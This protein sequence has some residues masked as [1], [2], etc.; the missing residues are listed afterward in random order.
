MERW[1]YTKTNFNIPFY[2]ICKDLPKYQ[3]NGLYDSKIIKQI[4]EDLKDE[5]LILKNIK[6]KEKEIFDNSLDKWCA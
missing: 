4:F 1:N 5:K 3:F 2:V 6:K